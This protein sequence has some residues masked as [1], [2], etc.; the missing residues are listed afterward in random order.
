MRSKTWRRGTGIVAV[1]LSLAMASQPVFA[2]SEVELERLKQIIEEQERRF[3]EQ[4]RRLAEQEKRLEEQARRIAEQEEKLQEQERLSQAQGLILTEQRDSLDNLWQRVEY[5]GGW[6]SLP[7][8]FTDRG[9][10][11]LV[12]DVTPRPPVPVPPGG[13]EPPTPAPPTPAPP[14]PTPP[15][16]TP[17]S[18]G[19]ETQA[20]PEDERPESEKPT[21]QLLVEAGGILLPPGVLQI[22]PAIEY[23]FADTD[24]VGINGFT[25]FEAIVIG[26]ISV[27]NLERNI[28]RSSVTG[29]MG[30]YDR[31]QI[32]AFVPYIYR[33]DTLTDGAGTADA[34][35]VDTDGHGLGDVQFGVSYQPVIGDGSLPDIILRSRASFPTGKDAF[36]IDTEDIDSSAGAQTV[37]E[38]APTG[39]GFYA[40]ENTAT[41]VWTADPVV[42][43]AGGGYT[44]N[45]EAEKNGQDIDP[46]DTIQFFG[47]INVALNESV[48]LNLSFTDQITDKTEVDGSRQDGTSFN[49]G[50]VVLGTSVG[51]SQD[52]SLLFS[53]AAGVTDEA[54]DFQFT[55]SV[56]VTVSLF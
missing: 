21:D 9:T 20:S 27:D 29:R 23:T 47:G 37:L 17:P 8:D 2:V 10:L 14:T 1:S 55:V 26:Q 45:F 50:R 28:I 22:E 52:M 19:P 46:G 42:F 5:A 30:V 25:V 12:Q 24:Q 39:S 41:F 38:E 35:D 53:A 4:E 18:A 13:S 44:I 54:P 3:Q 15:T 49:D 16:P 56:P 32:D 31:L 34:N 36:D 43:F 48:S 33:R 6:D 7:Y 51:V 40:L 11:T